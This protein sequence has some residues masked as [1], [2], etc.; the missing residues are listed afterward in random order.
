M[1]IVSEHQVIELLSVLKITGRGRD[2]FC[3]V[4]RSE[5]ADRPAL[6]SCHLLTF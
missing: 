3:M 2:F 6:H 5:H 4:L 1:V